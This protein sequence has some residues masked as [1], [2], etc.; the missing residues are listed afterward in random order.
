MMS[1]KAFASSLLILSFLFASTWAFV[2]RQLTRTPLQ[3]R[4]QGRLHMALPGNAMASLGL[5]LTASTGLYAPSSPPPSFHNQAFTSTTLS[6]EVESRQ[7]MYKEYTVEKTGQQ[8][9]NA[10]GTFKTKDETAGNKNKYVAILAVLLVGSC[11]IPMAQYF[12]Y[13]K[14]D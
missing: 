2:P 5:L 1:S 14:D 11:V 10:E 3:Q 4:G 6:K 9:E 8:Y 13:V 12:W 7:G